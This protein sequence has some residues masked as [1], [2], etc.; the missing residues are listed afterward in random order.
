MSASRLVLGIET[1][2]DDTSVAVLEDARHLRAHLIASQDLHRLYGGVVPELA[3]RAHLELLPKLVARGLTEAAVTPRDLTA[4]AVTRAPGLVGSLV[5]GVAFAKAYGFALGIPVTGVNHIEAHLH[6]AALEHGEAPAKA[7]ALVVS[8]GHTEL[9]EVRGFGRYRWLGSTRDD[10]VGEAYDKIAKRLGLPF[11]GGPHVDARA[12]AGNPFAYD[13]PRPM[14]D[15]PGYEFSFSGLKT[16]VALEADALGDPPLPEDRVAD[17]CASFQAAVVDTLAHKTMR[18]VDEIG[19]RSL[20]LG[21]GVACNRALRARLTAECGA[22]GVA[23][24]VPSP[25]L[26]ADNAA[27]VA[28]VGAWSLERGAAA[29]ASLEVVA[30]LEE[31]GLIEASAEV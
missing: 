23:L 18:A 25:R 29:D 24:R 3:A 2:C 20:T 19:A 5:V 1:S 9:V 11:P 26:C 6:A 12:A 31:S 21:G 28:L 22:R 16:A 14:L 13:F 15:R 7:I 8:G 17:L 27:M 30:S 4:E 10:A